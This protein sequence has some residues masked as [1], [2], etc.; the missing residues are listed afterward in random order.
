MGQETR[1]EIKAAY[2]S[3]KDAGKKALSGF[4]KKF[5][6]Q[7]SF[8]FCLSVK[9]HREASKSTWAVHEQWRTEVQ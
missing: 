7:G 1:E 9:A 4:K 6:E 5:S 3:A 2:R 8:D